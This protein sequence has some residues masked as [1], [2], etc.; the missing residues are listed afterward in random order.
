MP[1]EARHRHDLAQPL[2]YALNQYAIDPE[3]DRAGLAH[4]L[5]NLGMAFIFFR[6]AGTR[7]LTT[8]ELRGRAA[9]LVSS[10]SNGTFQRHWLDFT[11]EAERRCDAEEAGAAC[12]P[13]V[14]DD[15][16]NI[17]PPPPPPLVVGER[18]LRKATYCASK[19]ELGQAWRCF[20]PSPAEN[21]QL[22]SAKSARSSTS[23]R[24]VMGGHRSPTPT[25]RTSR[26]TRRSSSSRRWWPRSWRACPTSARLARSP[27]ITASS[28]SLAPMAA[29]PRSPLL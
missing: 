8:A 18:E 5:Y 29:S 20:Q 22:D 13:E 24:S 21:P 3:S 25:W 6:T 9:L 27:K 16:D 15:Y 23:T 2:V 4:W 26:A 17:T 10:V 28:N 7:P 1:R 19:G 11:A 12:T 14:F